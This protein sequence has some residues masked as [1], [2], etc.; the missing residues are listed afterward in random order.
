MPE[1]PRAHIG[2]YAAGVVLLAL[3]AFRMLGGDDGRAS[4]VVLDAPPAERPATKETGVHVHVAGAVSRPGVY[5]LPAGSRAADAVERAGGMTRRAD[6]VGV[7]LAAPL[8]DGQQVIV[9]ARVRGA[10]AV[11]GPGASAAPGAPVSLSTATLEQLD[12][13]DGIGPTLAQRILDHRDEHGGFGSVEE[14]RNVEG[15]GD[16]RFEALKDAVVP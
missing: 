13:L 11:T 8:R 3:L 9:P 15:I 7:N 12:S 2:W 1:I 5:S 10:P 16:K 14:L 6:P 4:A